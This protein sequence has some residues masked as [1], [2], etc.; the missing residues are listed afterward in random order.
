MNKKQQVS[1]SVNTLILINLI[2]VQFSALV[3][4]TLGSSSQNKCSKQL[5]HTLSQLYCISF[6]FFKRAKG[7]KGTK[8]GIRK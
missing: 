2:H 5:P 4:T 3:I 1:L 6:V 8:I 7:K